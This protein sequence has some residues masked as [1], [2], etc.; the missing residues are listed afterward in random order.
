[1]YKAKSNI[2]HLILNKIWLGYEALVLALY[3]G[4]FLSGDGE[5]EKDGNIFLDIAL[6]LP[7]KHLL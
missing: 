5:E 6:L 3:P 4:L 2:S 7:Q 1:M